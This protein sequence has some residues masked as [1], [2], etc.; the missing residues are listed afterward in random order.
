M[1]ECTEL[2]VAVTAAPALSVELEALTRGQSTNTSPNPYVSLRIHNRS[3]A[4]QRIQLFAAE[5][6]VARGERE[7]ALPLTPERMELRS[8][9]EDGE[10]VSREEAAWLELVTIPPGASRD[11]TVYTS[12][13]DAAPPNAFPYRVHVTFRDAEDRMGRVDAGIQRVIRD[14]IRR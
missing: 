13:L 3:E 8:L 5:L 9:F 6:W 1:P 12:A 10:P 7:V 4:P 14:P 11:V 2:D